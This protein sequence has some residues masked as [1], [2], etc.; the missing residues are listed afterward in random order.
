MS[1]GV[2]RTSNNRGTQLRALRDHQ[3][4]RIHCDIVLASTASMQGQDNRA[5]L[6]IRIASAVACVDEFIV[7]VRR[8]QRYHPQPVA[9]KLIGDDRSVGFDLHGIDG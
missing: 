6:A 5:L 8:I 3:I 4:P 7:D 1:D 2:A 9:K